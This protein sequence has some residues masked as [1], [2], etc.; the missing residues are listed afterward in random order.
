LD[1]LEGEDEW[2]EEAIANPNYN[3][4]GLPII[5]LPYLILMK[6]AASRTQYLADVS[7]MLGLTKEEELVKIRQVIKTY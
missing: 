7:R 3:P 6:L 1:V 5:A 4:D 2:V